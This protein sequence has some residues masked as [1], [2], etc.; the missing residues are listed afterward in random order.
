MLGFINK[1][2]TI[3]LLHTFTHKI[4]G[5]WMGV[6]STPSTALVP[7]YLQPQPTCPNEIFPN[8]INTCRISLGPNSVVKSLVNTTIQTGIEGF[9]LLTQQYLN[10]MYI[11]ANYSGT[12]AYFVQRPENQTN[13]TVHLN[14]NTP[15]FC[16]IPKQNDYDT[17]LTTALVGGAIGLM[18][19]GYKSVDIWNYFNPKNEES[20]NDVDTLSD[21][22][23]KLTIKDKK[24]EKQRWIALSAQE[25]KTEWENAQSQEDTTALIRLWDL[26][27]EIAED[28]FSQEQNQDEIKLGKSENITYHHFIKGHEGKLFMVDKKVLGQGS[29]GKVKSTYLKNNLLKKEENPWV[30]KVVPIKAKEIE[31]EAETLN[32]GG[33]LKEFDPEKSDMVVRELGNIKDNLVKKI[34]LFQPR[35]PGEES[36]NLIHGH[37]EKNIQR[38][39]L[40]QAQKMIIALLYCGELQRVHDK[41]LMHLDIKPE[42]YMMHINP[43]DRYDITINIIDFGL[44]R[45]IIENDSKSDGLGTLGYM[46]P[47]LRKNDPEAFIQ[48]DIFAL[49]SVFKNDLGLESKY[50]KKMIKS[51]P[52]DRISLNQVMYALRKELLG[53]NRTL[54]NSTIEKVLNRFNIVK[55]VRSATGP[56]EVELNYKNIIA[57]LIYTLE[58]ERVNILTDMKDR[59]TL[60]SRELVLRNIINKL[61]ELKSTP[62]DENIV[63]DSCE[64]LARGIEDVKFAI[65]SQ[66]ATHMLMLKEMLEKQYEIV[67]KEL[68]L[69]NQYSQVVKTK[70]GYYQKLNID[71]LNIKPYS[72]LLNDLDSEEDIATI[73]QDIAES[74]YDNLDAVQGDELAA[75]INSIIEDISDIDKN[76]YASFIKE[77]KEESTGKDVISQTLVQ[78]LDEVLQ[79]LQIDLK[80]PKMLRFS[81]SSTSSSTGN[82]AGSCSSERKLSL[83]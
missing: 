33:I 53:L 39:D 27:W 2:N 5:L 10:M 62:P 32:E 29:S 65:D 82:S 61:I 41:R 11:P 69:L 42:N 4:S 50:I 52:T 45:R 34:Y 36:A 16:S 66:N 46:A 48:T 18:F 67:N 60:S 59:Q 80:A 14:N 79:K 83:K 23:K 72:E 12:P 63:L 57:K 24:S 74:Y 3:D 71:N 6:E 35:H 55:P 49:G 70:Q 31:K 43:D 21:E 76:K 64:L 22:L 25:R 78:I 58:K 44:S 20:K 13:F 77:K 54:Q 73:I 75:K 9:N 15:Y 8:P 7:V 19:T 68:E 56:K 37:Q 51:V 47:E 1:F 38:V 26:E 17:A 28:F 81:N 40:D 30:V